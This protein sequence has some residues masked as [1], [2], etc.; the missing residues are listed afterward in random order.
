MKKSTPRVATELALLLVCCLLAAG[1]RHRKERVPAPPP[2]AIGSL[3]P[4]GTILSTE[5]GIAS[6]YRAADGTHA[7]GHDYG[8][9]AMTAAHRTL[10][11]GTVVRVTDLDTRRSALV[12]ITDRGPFIPGRILDLSSAAAKKIGMYRAG[13]AKVRMDVLRIPNSAQQNSGRWCVQ[14]GA[15]QHS[16]TAKKLKSKLLRQYPRARVIQFKGETGYWVRIQP[17]GETLADAEQ[18][19]RQMHLSEGRAYIL[20]LH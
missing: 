14:V 20:R 2:P 8:K 7:N 6:W 18:L 15:L 10:P 17:D 5:T 11:F 16:G 9:R 12:T 19:V 1:C 3:G 4:H 13:V